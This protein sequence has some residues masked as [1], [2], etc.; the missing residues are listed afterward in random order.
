MQQSLSLELGVPM[1]MWLIYLMDCL[2][3]Y[4]KIDEENDNST[5][6]ILTYNVFWELISTLDYQKI[7]SR[8]KKYMGTTNSE[9]GHGAQVK[10]SRFIL[11]INVSEKCQNLPVI[12]LKK[13]K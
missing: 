5:F 10:H 12:F 7:A 8:N 9:K 2:S 11:L 3:F 1:A 13:I 4:V 6:C